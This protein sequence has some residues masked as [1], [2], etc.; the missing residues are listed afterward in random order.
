MGRLVE[1]EEEEEEARRTQAQTVHFLRFTLG[2][3]G[4]RPRRLGAIVT[5]D[6]HGRVEV[7]F[8]L[9]VFVHELITL[10]SPKNGSPAYQM[11]V[12]SAML[13]N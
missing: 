8:S 9:S 7:A 2:Q 11:Y 5:R 13:P 4:T 6:Y 12:L 3:Q 10:G 1:E